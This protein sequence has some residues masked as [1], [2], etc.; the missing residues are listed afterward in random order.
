MLDYVA[1]CRYDGNMKHTQNATLEAALRILR[2]AERDT[3]PQREDVL[4]LLARAQWHVRNA[5][6]ETGLP[7]ATLTSPQTV[8]FSTSNQDQYNAGEVV[9]V[10]PACE[11]PDLTS[12]WSPDHLDELTVCRTCGNRAD[13]DPIV[14]R[15]FPEFCPDWAAIAPY[16]EPAFETI[17]VAA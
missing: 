8:Q 12:L 1:L 11:S 6:N 7:V 3:D 10:C 13:R 4:I 17:E 2:Q 16:T 14:T 5:K 9:F 15:H